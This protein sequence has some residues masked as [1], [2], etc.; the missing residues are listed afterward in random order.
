MATSEGD[1][2]TW[3]DREIGLFHSHC[4]HPANFSQIDHDM[5]ISRYPHLWHMI[6]SVRNRSMPQVRIFD[7]SESGSAQK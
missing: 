1:V 4:R 6:I 5:H 2:E 7:V 3:C